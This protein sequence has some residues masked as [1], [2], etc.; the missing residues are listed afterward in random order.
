[1]QF[2]R[3]I[4]NKL[5]FNTSASFTRTITRV[6]AAAVS[7]SVMVV[8]LA[9]GILLGFKK[10]IRQ[11]VTGYAGD[12]T[13]SAYQV[14][15]GTDLSLLEL[16]ETIIE[17]I[18][19]EPEVESVYPFLTKAGIIKTDSLLEGVLFKGI[20]HNY[21][22]SFYQKHLLKGNLPV[23]TDSTDRY[24]ILLSEYTSTLLNL[25]TGDRV[26]LFFIEGSDVKRRR[27]RICGIF[28]THLQE[29]DKQFA[30]AD[31]RV[32]QRIVH[33][34]YTRIGGYE[35]N[36]RN[37]K[38]IEETKARI[39]TLLPY[40][41]EAKSVMERYP[42]LFQW[43]E[44]VDT[45]VVIIIVLMFVVAVINIVTI[46]LILII[47][48]IPMIGILKS[49]GA[50]NTSIMNIFSWQGIYIVLS[51]LVI[52]NVLAMGMGW[53]Q[54][55][56]KVVGLEADTY[57]MDAVPFALPFSYWLLINLGALVACYAFT[58]LPVRFL[59][60]IQPSQSIRFK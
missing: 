39:N 38:T 50:R 26:D 27:I 23:Y 47:D 30:I 8:L 48:R 16:S 24:D 45:N 55:Q 21:D 17:D 5:S 43:L 29:F 36:V 41:L 52:G 9:Y 28:N 22:L 33:P 40:E 53:L 46:L 56:Y 10:E 15:Q 58:Y 4:A 19:D 42:T 32:I 3:F 12:I 35:V 60:N 44:I 1:M 11:K 57:Y 18:E 25:D 31:L 13:V 34:S 6:A 2:S 14:A 59:S 7:L 49:M 20:P 51:G 54:A 37:F